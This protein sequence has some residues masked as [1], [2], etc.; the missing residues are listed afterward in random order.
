V[1][2]LH[3]MW[4]TD[5]PIP[6]G[7][8]WLR[9]RAD[10]LGDEATRALL[11]SGRLEAFEYC[12]KDGSTKP[13]TTQ[14]WL[15]EFGPE[16]LR[17]GF[18]THYYH[19]GPREKDDPLY[20]PFQPQPAYSYGSEWRRLCVRCAAPESVESTGNNSPKRLAILEAVTAIYGSVD[21][22]KSTPVK[23]RDAAINKWMR[24]NDRPEVDLKTIRRTLP[25]R[26]RQNRPK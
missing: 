10:K 1:S 6:A 9:T 8:E 24:D 22:S 2:Y 12:R 16:M 21:R 11:E 19:V 5:E 7:Y 25:P 18:K 20:D 17:S 26:S 3:D 14:D 13:V 23:A 15:S 4:P